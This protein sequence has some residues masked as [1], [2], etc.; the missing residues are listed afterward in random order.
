M[1]GKI[2][3]NET[4]T[5]MRQGY[6]ECEGRRIDIKTDMEKSISHSILFT[7]KQGED[8]LKKYEKTSVPAAERLKFSEVENISTVDAI[9]KMTEEGRKEIGVLNFA[10]A[11]NAGDVSTEPWR[12][13]KALRHPVRFTGHCWPMRNIIK[14]T[15]RK[16][17]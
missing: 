11:R 2:I 3:A 7:P 6:Y 12:R 14:A 4:L 5:I 17:P 9:R 8:I 16:I 15:G 1:D 13:R 10:S